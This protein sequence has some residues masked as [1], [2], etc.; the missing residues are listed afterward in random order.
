MRNRVVTNRHQSIRPEG[1]EDMAAW[2]AAYDAAWCAGASR[3]E[4]E[5]AAAKAVAA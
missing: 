2:K 5:R 1:V 3:E 4:C